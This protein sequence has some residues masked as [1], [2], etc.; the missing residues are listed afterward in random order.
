MSPATARPVE[1]EPVRMSCWFGMSPTPLTDRAFFVQRERLVDAVAIALHVAMEIGNVVGNELTTCVEPRTRTDAVTRI[2]GR[3]TTRG[4]LA[5]V[6]APGTSGRRRESATLSHLRAVG[7]GSGNAAVV[8]AVTLADTGDE[9]R[10]W[11]RRCGASPLAR[12]SG[13]ASRL[14]RRLGKRHER[15]KCGKCSRRKNM[16]HPSH[17]DF[18]PGTRDSGSATREPVSSFR[19]WPEFFRVPRLRVSDPGHSS[20]WFWCSV[21]LKAGKVSTLC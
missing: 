20:D 12:W 14:L 18:L 3:L 2:H 10:R 11:P 21:R 1:S 16:S 6:R 15:S 8:G 5:Q 19:L 9:E 4:W 7:I 13:S 17:L